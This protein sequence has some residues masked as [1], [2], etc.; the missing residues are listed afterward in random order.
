MP[1]LKEITDFFETLAPLKLQESYDNAGLIIGDP[2]STI[3]SAIVTLDVTEAVIEEAV[4]R[5]SNL[6]IAH[7]PV[8]FSG[9]K[10]LDFP[11]FFLYLL[12]MK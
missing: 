10:K 2:D 1:L 9:L 12:K 6:I 8:I 5:G 3:S 11:T 7:H 4:Q